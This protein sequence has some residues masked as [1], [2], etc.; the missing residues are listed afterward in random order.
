MR[1]KINLHQHLKGRPAAATTRRGADGGGW[2]T[3]Q[4]KSASVQRNVPKYYYYNYTHRHSLPST[5][6][7]KEREYIAYTHLHTSERSH[8]ERSQEKER[9]SREPRE[10]WYSPAAVERVQCRVRLARRPARKRPPW[11][12]A[13]ALARFHLIERKRVGM[14]GERTEP[15]CGPLS[16][17]SQSLAALSAGRSR[18]RAFAA[19]HIGV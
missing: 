14:S 13:A 17:E 1:K 15:S 10:K 16:L 9:S 11:P 7:V 2:G 12:A 4:K 8:R 18:D 19:V 6:G 3:A 5:E